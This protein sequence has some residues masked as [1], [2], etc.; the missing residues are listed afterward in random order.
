MPDT[1]ETLTFAATV[2]RSI[3]DVAMLV[4]VPGAIVLAILLALDN[5]DLLLVPFAGLTVSVLLAAVGLGAQYVQPL[6]DVLIVTACA[7]AIGTG[8]R[9]LR[10]RRAHLARRAR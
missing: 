3:A 6:I 2:S 7:A 8:V 9:V 1:I 10:E 5:V 4:A